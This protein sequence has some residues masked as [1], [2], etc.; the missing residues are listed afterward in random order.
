MLFTK[1]RA[2]PAYCPNR[3]NDATGDLRQGQVSAEGIP[4]DSAMI[5]SAPYDVFAGRYLTPRDSGCA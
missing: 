1:S 2:K 3:E 5:V 4:S